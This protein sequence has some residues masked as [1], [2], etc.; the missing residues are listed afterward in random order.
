MNVKRLV[1]RLLEDGDF[2]PDT[3]VLF[4]AMDVPATLVGELESLA[5][6]FE[7]VSHGDSEEPGKGGRLRDITLSGLYADYL[8][9]KEAI[10]HATD[11]RFRRI[12]FSDNPMDSDLFKKTRTELPF[13]KPIDLSDI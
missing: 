7:V 10:M 6:K 5:E 11:K 1:D 12:K 2:K 3:P 4:V 9:F 8:R 13:H